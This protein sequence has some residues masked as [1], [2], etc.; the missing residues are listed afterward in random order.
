MTP[1]PR[2]Q[3]PSFSVVIPTYRR[4]R[5]LARVLEAL[6]RQDYPPDLLEVLVVDDG[7]DDGSVEMV[8]AL[9]LP[10]PIR[11]LEQ[12]NQGPA[13]ARNLGVQHARHRFLLFLDDDVVPSPRLVAEHAAAH[14]GRS[15]RVVMGTMLGHGRERTPWVRWEAESLLSQYDAMDAGVF[16]PTP[17]QFYTGNASVLREHVLCV[18]GFDPRYRRAEDVE[19]AL[20]LWRRLG[21]CFVFNRSAE[22][23]HIAERSHGAWLDSARQYG[24]NDVLFGVLEERGLEQLRRRHPY[25]RRLV[26]WGLRHLRLRRL[27]APLTAVAATF[28][29]WVGLRRLSRSLCSAIFN[30]HYWIGVEAALG[31]QETRRLVEAALAGRESQRSPTLPI[32]PGRKG[33]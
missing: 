2:T 5:S 29:Y 25:T 26:R 24:R 18:G 3:W 27:L 19:L 23:V 10:F 21:L 14:C 31:V 9:R 13:A 4:R 15:D 33:A 7:G 30:L 8:R 22:A 12:P 11:A 20:R 6:A 28:A 16:E 32:G 17:W 1:A